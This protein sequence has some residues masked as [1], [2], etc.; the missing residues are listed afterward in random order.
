MRQGLLYRHLEYRE[1]SGWLNVN[2]PRGYRSTKV[3]SVIKKITGAKKVGHGGTLDPMATGVL[4]IC[5]NGATTQ[6]EFLMDHSKTYLFNLTFGESRDT[7][8]ADGNT[9]N[10]NNLVPEASAL[11]SILSN[12]SGRIEQKPPSFSAIRIDGKRAY[13]LARR[14]IQ[15]ELREREILINS[16]KFNGF[17]NSN[18]AQFLVDCGRGC[19]VRSLAV[20]IAG[21]VGALGYVS[22]L[23]RLRVGSLYATDSLEIAGLTP[24]NVARNLI[25][26]R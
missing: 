22:K 13:D 19:Y 15:L 9:I 14:G 7:Y 1:F 10:R 23:V 6:T 8:D 2:K 25:V 4:P 3:V 12:F 26:Y 11:E 24:D 20:D 18:T 16:L 5:L 17:I 21:A